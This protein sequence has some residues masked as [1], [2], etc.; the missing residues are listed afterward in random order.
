MTRLDRQRRSLSSHKPY[1]IPPPPTLLSKPYGKSTRVPRDAVSLPPPYLTSPFLLLLFHHFLTLC[2]PPPSSFL[3]SFSSP[4]YFL[5][6]VWT[7]SPTHIWLLQECSLLP[8]DQPQLYLWK[9]QESSDCLIISVSTCF[10]VPSK[11]FLSFLCFNSE[12]L[13]FLSSKIGANL[14]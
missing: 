13:E 11:Q 14:V 7:C 9:I 6:S 8:L 5:L 4:F 12:S 10:F 2:P 3:P 1:L